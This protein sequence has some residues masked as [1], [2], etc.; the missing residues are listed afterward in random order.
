MKITENSLTN[1][2]GSPRVILSLDGDL[3]ATVL[4]DQEV[5]YL[6]GLGAIL[7]HKYHSI[8]ANNIPMRRG[9]LCQER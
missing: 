2:G 9:Q 8:A 5:L 3:L 1:L 4:C 7:D 6:P